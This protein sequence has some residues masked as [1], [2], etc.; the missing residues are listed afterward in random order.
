MMG[1]QICCIGQRQTE[2]R[3]ARLSVPHRGDSTVYRTPTSDERT[4]EE[5]AKSSDEAPAVPSHPSL[6]ESLI[7]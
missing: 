4:R 1:T 3:G 5:A 7:S 2:E 6:M